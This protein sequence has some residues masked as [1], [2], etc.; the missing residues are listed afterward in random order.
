MIVCAEASGAALSSFTGD[1]FRK[2]LILLTD[3]FHFITEPT[4][5]LL[6]TNQVRGFR[7]PKFLSIEDFLA[8]AVA[9]E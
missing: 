5:T 6:L 2:L 7:D 4:T 1:E 3:G 8:R 9:F